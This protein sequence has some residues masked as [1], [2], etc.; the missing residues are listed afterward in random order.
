MTTDALFAACSTS[1]A[2]TGAA[3]SIAIQDSQS[4][5]S[6]IHWSTT[7]ASLIPGEFILDDNYATENIT[8]EDALSHRTGMPQHNWTLA[9]F[10]KIGPTPGSIVRAMRYMPLTTPPR[11][12]YHYS[13]H[14]YIAVSH[15][16]EQ[17]TGDSLGAF[18]KKRIW[19]PL[20][21]SDTYFGVAEARQNS[22]NSVKLVQG[23]DWI[24]TKEG[25]AFVP[26]PENYWLANSGAG[27]IVSNVLDYG[28]W[29]RELIEKEGPLKG[30]ETVTDPRTICFQ[31]DD[32][33]LPAP[34]H[35]Y[36]L[37][38]LVD[39]Y[40]GE[41][42]YSHGGGWPGYAC[43]VGF[44]PSKKFG[45]VVMGNSSSARYAAFR[46][47]TYLLDKHLDLPADP[48]YQEQIAACTSR[49]TKEWHARLKNEEPDISKQR[50]FPWLPDPPIPHTLP[51]SKYA[52]SYKHPTETTVTFNIDSGSL[53]ADLR[54]RVIPCE[55]CLD[56]ASGNYFVGRI[57]SAGLDLMPPFAVEFCLENGVVTNVGLCLEPDMKREK[58][59]FERCQS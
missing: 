11:T 5:E 43:W 39:S 22:L 45:F 53:T 57:H 23:Y 17:Y 37:G 33:N 50:L 29:V 44:I 52:G 20:G 19:E 24:P 41:Y 36:A 54:D 30:H 27:A 15:A 7:L 49:Q 25:G 40:R 51:L 34:F 28:R 56:H 14:M 3:T 55:L 31:N 1:K 13:N 32:L 26:K 2:F 10:P 58:I 47:I 42:L 6:P 12:K 46:L 59:W 38:W 18:M 16:L 9:L 35:T 4:T 8:L 48:A 21:M